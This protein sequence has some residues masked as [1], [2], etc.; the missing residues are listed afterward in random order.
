MHLET[1]SRVAFVPPPAS[2]GTKERFATAAGCP[3]WARVTRVWS[4]R[5]YPLVNLKCESDDREYTS[6]P[7]RSEVNGADSFFYLG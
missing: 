3:E 7:H 6:V 2:A 4:E 1:G 5:S